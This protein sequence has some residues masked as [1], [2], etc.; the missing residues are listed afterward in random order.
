[1]YIQLLSI[2]YLDLDG[3]Q[4]AYYPGDWVDV[5]KSTALQWVRDGEAKA[6]EK[7]RL[8]LPEGCGVVMSCE[9]SDARSILSHLST[10]VVVGGSLVYEKTLFYTPGAPLPLSL[11]PVGF[12]FLDKWEIAAPLWSYTELA[13]DQGTEEERATTKK[14]IRDLRV[15]TYDTRLIF[16]RRCP[17]VQELFTAMENEKVTDQES[18]LRLAFMRVVYQVKPLILALPTTWMVQK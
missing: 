8:D 5:G 15:P 18:N 9:S 12:K 11:I 17:R 2:K 4:K 14:V 6:F 1:M 7:I 10:P 13:A 16:M 3:W